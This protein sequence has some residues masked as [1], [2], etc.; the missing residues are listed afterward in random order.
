MHVPFCSGACDYCDFYSVP[1]K[2][3]DRRLAAYVDKILEDCEFVLHK[4]NINHIPSVYIGGGT[5]SVLGAGLT[6]RLL[7]GLNS[8][9]KTGDLTDIPPMEI[10]IEALM[11][12]E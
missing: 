11:D 1:V 5:P 12:N 6:G 2:P 10:T 8:Y 7:R 4:H 9:W 3:N